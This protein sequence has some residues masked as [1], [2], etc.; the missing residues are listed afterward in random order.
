MPLSTNQPN[1][2]KLKPNFYDFVTANLLAK[3]EREPESI[4]NLNLA[5]GEERRNWVQM[6]KK[7]G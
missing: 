3:G 2:D 6:K 5:T 4:V 7:A 1:L